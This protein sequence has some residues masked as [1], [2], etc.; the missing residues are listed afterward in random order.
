MKRLGEGGPVLGLLPQAAYNATTVEVEPGD[1]LVMY[2]DGLVEAANA[3]DDE[4]GEER[5]EALLRSHFNETPAKIRES[6]MTSWVSFSPK[7][8]ARDDL[9][10]TIIRF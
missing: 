9:T 10:I 4:Y 3:A 7:S 8:D 5:L 1:L 6:L 2:S